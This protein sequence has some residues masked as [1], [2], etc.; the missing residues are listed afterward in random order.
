MKIETKYEIGQHI[1]II[2]EDRGQ[3]Y[4]Y[5]DYIGFITYEDSLMY[6][7][8]EAC[9]DLNEDQIVLYED[10][11]KLANLIKETMIQIRK[12]EKRGE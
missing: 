12:K 6:T 3:V 11:E 2:E 1:W 5:D 8:K 7:T 9:V 4:V 10:L